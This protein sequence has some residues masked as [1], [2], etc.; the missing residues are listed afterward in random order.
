MAT[1]ALGTKMV[2][3][4]IDAM[5]VPHK[6]RL[7]RLRL[8]GGEPLPVRKIRG[9]RFLARSPSGDEETIEVQ[10]FAM[11]GGRPSNDRLARTGRIDLLV[12]SKETGER[13]LVATR[14]EVRGP[15]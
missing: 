10:G 2:F 6:G 4:V 9:A 1:A 12:T 13:P 11:V 15:V 8:Q 7:I 14:W 5:D 3:R